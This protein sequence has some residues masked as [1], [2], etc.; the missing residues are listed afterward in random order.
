MI[1]VRSVLTERLKPDPILMLNPKVEGFHTFLRP[2]IL[3][4]T[5]PFLLLLIKFDFFF[6]LIL[7][8]LILYFQPS[9]NL[10]FAL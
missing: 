8:L 3:I 2:L 10:D 7:D 4:L 9:S 1:V 5:L 6:D